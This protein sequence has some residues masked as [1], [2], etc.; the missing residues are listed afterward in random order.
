M[1]AAPFNHV[2]VFFKQQNRWLS[3]HD[4][5]DLNATD[6]RDLRMELITTLESLE[7]QEQ[8]HSKAAADGG[9]PLDRDWLARLGVK[10][11]ASRLA[12]ALIE[13]VQKDRANQAAAAAERKLAQVL[14]THDLP[15]DPQ[16]LDAHLAANPAQ[17]KP[18]PVVIS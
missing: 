13:Q 1:S 14:L 6:L 18:I 3:H 2:R 11:R 15:T 7:F 9:K 16:R 5:H 4:V 12:L 17:S 10:R 8:K